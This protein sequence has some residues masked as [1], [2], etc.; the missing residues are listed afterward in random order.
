MTEQ[1]TPLTSLLLI[2]LGGAAGSV[3]RYLFG[4]FVQ[5]A[6][7][8]FPTG[9][10]AVNTVGGILIGVL[11]GLAMNAQTHASLRPALIVGFCG[12]FT[13]FSTFS[14]ETVSLIQG[15]AVGKAALYVAASVTLSLLGTT[16]GFAL[17][18]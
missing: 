3:A 9:T 18:R 6:T 10:L 4:G 14:M 17:T 15:G 12:G 16:L 7:H 11:T 5:G 13:T 1:I 8:V 2:A